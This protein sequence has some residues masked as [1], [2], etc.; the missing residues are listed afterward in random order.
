MNNLNEFTNLS[1][2]LKTVRFGL[3]PEEG[4][5]RRACIFY[6]SLKIPIISM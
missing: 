6:Y 2:I 4:T 5:L 1:Q 3:K